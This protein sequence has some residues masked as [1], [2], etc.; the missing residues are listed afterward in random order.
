[1][2]T[3]EWKSPEE[4]KALL[5][6]HIQMS[7][8]QGRR[9]ESQSDYRAVLVRKRWGVLERREILEV[10]EYGNVSIQRL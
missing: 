6:R 4:R 2:S 5:D 9:V 8:V 7:V 1:M 10:D 3:P